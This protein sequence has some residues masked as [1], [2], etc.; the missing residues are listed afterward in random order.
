[1]IRAALFLCVLVHKVR[2]GRH[3]GNTAAACVCSAAWLRHAADTASAPPHCQMKQFGSPSPGRQRGDTGVAGCKQLKKE[4]YVRVSRFGN[5]VKG[6]GGRE[7][8]G[9]AQ[10]VNVCRKILQCA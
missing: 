5:E 8:N 4:V 10:A 7:G 2:R 3:A 6:K 9:G 1:M